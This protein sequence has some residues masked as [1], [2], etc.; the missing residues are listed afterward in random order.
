MPVQSTVHTPPASHPPVQ[1]GGH[2]A[3]GW[4]V[5]SGEQ[6]A[7]LSVGGA[8][9]PELVPAADRFVRADESAPAPI[10]R[11]E[12]PLRRP[13]GRILHLGVSVSPYVDH[14]GRDAGTIV[15]VQDLTQ[16]RSMEEAVKTSERLAA[17]GEVAAGL[18][19]ELR[20]PLAAL[21]G[22]IELLRK[23]SL[24]KDDVNGQRLMDIVLRETE[25]LDGLVSD[26]L[27]Y[28][29]PAPPHVEPVDLD[30]LVEDTLAVFRNDVALGHTHG[31]VAN[32]RGGGRRV[33]V[34]VGQIKQVL[35][36][37]LINALQAMPEGGAIRVSTRPRAGEEGALVIEVEDDGPGIQP[38]DMRRIF[39]PFF[40]TKEGGTGLG[41]A[42][43]YRI[44][45]AHGGRID[46]HSAWGHGAT[47]QITLPAGDEP[48][49]SDGNTAVSDGGAAAR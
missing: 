36:N 20:N 27:G 29:R 16:L 2:C 23:R 49:R 37:L 1:A 40:T 19:H 6:L 21:S 39:E 48:A 47:F 31:L 24:A 18:A 8:S 7:G 43:V 22:S 15:I 32:L 46:V 45:E 38:A 42:T 33:R 30:R 11:S 9:P 26:F 41:L 34:D 3:A 12:I 25:R 35:W 4:G 10:R 14:I 28:A 44:V 5:G 17:I 13:D